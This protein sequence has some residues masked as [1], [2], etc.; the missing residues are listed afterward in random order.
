MAKIGK[1]R[2]LS[3]ELLIQL[4][5]VALVPLGATIVFFI[6]QLFPYLTKNIIDEQQSIASL[7]TQQ[8]IERI[9][10]AEEQA[11]LLIGLAAQNID[12]RELLEGFLSQKSDFDTV[13]FL[14]ETGSIKSIAI[15]DALV[16]ETEQLYMDMD[17][18]HSSVYQN[19][20]RVSGWTQVFLSIVTGRLSIAYFEQMGDQRLIAELAIDRL[21]QLSKRL[22]ELDILVMLVDGDNQLIA[23]PDPSLSQQQFNL[24]NLALFKSSNRQSVYSTDFEWDN[25]KYFGTLVA[26]EDLGWSVIVAEE[27]SSIWA[28]LYQELT[29]WLISIATIIVLALLIALKRSSQFS[30]RFAVLSQ[31]AKN[32]ARG[33]YQTDVLQERVREF[34]ELSE[35]VV[36]M[37]QAISKREDALQAKERQ[38]R[39]INEVLEERVEERTTR[40]IQ[41]NQELEKTNSALNDTMDQLVHAEK[42]AALGSLVAGVAHELNTPIGNAAMA[43]SSLQDFAEQIQQQ[44]SE[45]SVTK[46]G[47]NQFLS[48]SIMAAGIT[49]RNL[50][51]AAELITSFKQV[52]TD[53]SSSQ[54][55]EFTIDEL[56]HEILLTLHPQTKKKAVNIELDISSEAKL[57]SYPGPLGQVISNLIMNAFIHGFDDRDEGHIKI[58][59]RRE[60]PAVKLIIEDDGKGIPEASIARI[61]DPFYT[62]KLGQG[63]S[64]LGLH[65][66]HNIVIDVLGGSIKVESKVHQGTT[67]LI[68]LAATAPMLET[69]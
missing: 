7:V 67:F 19:E 23:H 32:I 33:N 43:S 58:T 31:Q 64:G 14:D 1:T 5:I 9:T 30:K 53:Q 61:F 21:P 48:D 38:L 15:R 39:E 35:N 41:S 34:N 2:S 69:E 63:G 12:K 13:Y 56:L 22:S 49:A 6:W 65:I 42:L 50:E 46:S 27:E 29:K 17:L 10:T 26:M 16:L 3:S 60:G 18:S 51:K 8:V 40:L 44:L 62:T 57:D 54:R 36:E 66:C 45:G 20:G 11:G 25:Q 68:T 28:G 37:S 59:A 55:R 4:A 52:A 47:L 24:G